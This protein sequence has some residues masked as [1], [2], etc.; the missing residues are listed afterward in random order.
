MDGTQQLVAVG[1]LG[2][3]GVNYWTSAQRSAIGSTVWNGKAP[4]AARSAL[5]AIAGELLLVF[6]LTMVAGQ[7]DS[8]A[9][10]MLAILA[11]LWVLW[12]M[13]HYGS[14]GAKRSTTTTA[15]AA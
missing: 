15:Q 4:A 3:V 13:Q 14:G 9:Y 1:G 5:L 11:A 12:S 6:I 8:L 7:S 10:G 2:L